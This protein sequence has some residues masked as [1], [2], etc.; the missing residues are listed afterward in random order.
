MAKRRKKRA[1]KRATHVSQRRAQHGGKRAGAGRKPAL[2][3]FQEIAVGGECERLW[4]ALADRKALAQ[5]DRQ[6]RALGIRDEQGRL[7]RIPLPLR[8]MPQEEKRGDGL[9]VSETLAEVSQEIDIALAAGRLVSI[10]LKRPRSSHAKIIARVI[11]WCVQ[12]YSIKITTRR[13][14]HCWKKF[15]SLERQLRTET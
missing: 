3:F 11:E 9:T 10:P 1:R 5:H 13:T 12:N 15:R 2:S 8:K 4:L 14:E 7:N 6:I